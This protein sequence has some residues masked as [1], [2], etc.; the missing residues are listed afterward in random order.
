VLMTASPHQ[1]DRLRDWTQ[2]LLHAAFLLILVGTAARFLALDTPQCWAIVS[3]SALLVAGYTVGIGRWDRG[4]GGFWFGVLFAL[5]V[6]LLVVVP[7]SLTSTFS[8]CAVPLVCL[9]ARV[10]DRTWALVVLIVVTVMLLVLGVWRAVGFQPDVVLA[11]IAAIWAAAGLYRLQQRDA[12]ELRVARDELAVSRQEAG[13]LAERARIARDIHDTLAQ[14]IAGSRMLL[15]AAD[16]DRTRHPETAWSRVR[17]VT[18]SLGANLAETRRIIAD[19]LP[20]ALDGQDLTAALTDL[21]DQLDRAG[22][23]TSFRVVGAVEPVPSDTAIAVLRV[24]QGALGNVRDHAGARSVSVLLQRA[25][26]WLTLTV[27]DDGVGFD[28]DHPVASPGRGFGLVAIRERVDECGGT[29]TVRSEPGG[30]TVLTATVGV[31][32]VVAT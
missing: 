2:H 3:L 5:W 29:L 21:C 28:P 12:D 14:D 20:R 1:S 22:V 15:Q 19:L 23:A 8:W 16:R 6:T 26:N 27:R 17:A 18:E 31:A 9:A 30:G 7:S 13:V 25:G 24:A 10:L 11:P 32:L 4:H